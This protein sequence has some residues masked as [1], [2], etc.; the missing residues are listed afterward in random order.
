[1]AAQF[2]LRLLALPSLRQAEEAEAAKAAGKRRAAQ[3]GGGGRRTK[4][5]RRNQ[6]PI[7]TIPI[8]AVAPGQLHSGASASAGTVADGISSTSAGQ[9]GGPTAI[10]AESAGSGESAW[11][12]ALPGDCSDFS[13]RFFFFFFFNWFGAGG[14]SLAASD[15]EESSPSTSAAVPASDLGAETG[16]QTSAVAA[17][18]GPGEAPRPAAAPEALAARAGLAASSVLARGARAKAVAADHPGAPHPP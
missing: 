18:G 12:I 13:S 8:R 4:R 3:G 9:D 6:P 17:P 5:S 15:A 11:T 1:M 7:P 2:N 16:L 14:G 10:T